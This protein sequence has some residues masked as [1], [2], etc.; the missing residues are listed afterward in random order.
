MPHGKI[1]DARAWMSA[2]LQ[3]QYDCWSALNKAKDAKMVNKT[4]TFMDSLTGLTSNALSMVFAY[5]GYGKETGSWAV[6]EKWGGWRVQS[7]FQG[8][9]SNELKGGRDGV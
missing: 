5:D 9:G 4:I 6:G 7:G 8:R 2:A 1:K 3:F